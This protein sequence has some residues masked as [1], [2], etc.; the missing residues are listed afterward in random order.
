[1]DTLNAIHMSE[2]E[3]ELTFI[4]G[5][6]IAGTLSSWHEPA[7]LLE[8]ATLAVAARSGG[9]LDSLTESLTEIGAR[10]PRVELLASPEIDISSSLVR[11]RAA[12]GAPLDQLVGAE[13]ARYIGEH[14]L[15]GARAREQVSR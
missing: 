4:L 1:V 12:A 6:D 9:E 2:P 13:V 14:G 3:A 8:L 7:R 15:Y 11:E 5:A 10:A